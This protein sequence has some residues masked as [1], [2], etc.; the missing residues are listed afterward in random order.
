MSRRLTRPRDGLPSLGNPET[1][2]SLLKGGGATADRGVLNEKKSPSE[3]SLHPGTGPTHPCL[4][5][6][7]SN[8]DCHLRDG[9]G[10]HRAVRRAPC[11]RPPA[12]SEDNGGT[13]QEITVTATRRALSA[14]DIP[15]SITAVSGEALEQAGI[16][17][18][19][20]LAHSMAGVNYT[21]RGPFGGV[22]G[23]TLIM[24]GLNSE[25][26]AFQEG[27]A[28]SVIPPV[29]TYVDD[30]PLFFNM[31]LQDLQRVEVLRG[32]QGTLYGS[33]S[34]GGTIRFVLNEPDPT[35]FDAKAEAG[36]SKT[37]HTHTTN[38]DI[39]GMI[40]LPLSDTLAV[41]INAGA[42][43]DAGFVNQTNLYVVDP[44]GVPVFSQQPTPDNALGLNPQIGPKTYSEQGV[45][46]YQYRNARLSVLWK[47]N[48]DFKAQL[49]YL[50]QRST[51]NG[52]P[53]IAANP[54]AYTQPI[55]A[56]NQFLP[57]G[58]QTPVSDP[59]NLLSLAPATVP[60]GTDRLT[61]ANNSLEGTADDVNLVSLSL[62][63]DMGFAT[64]TSSS[65]WAHHN[66]TSQFRPDRRIHQF[67]LLPEFIRSKSSQHH[68]RDGSAR[69]QDL[70][71]GI[72]PDLEDRRRLRLDRGTVLQE[73]E[74]QHRG[75]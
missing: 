25:S 56:A 6:A 53:I 31:R 65:S 70:C 33:G 55:A 32:P 45:N 67:Q 59:P 20:G 58:Q 29:A 63:Y 35:G 68:Q 37:N 72:S 36:V 40:N 48:E 46:S 73:P 75:T 24:R 3:T 34:L 51:A 49:T 69:R 2:E 47:P 27:L 57:Y 39:S 66:N 16:Q 22:N 14:Q 43:D 21:D 28:T 64:L 26:T 15:I 44:S 7:A 10:A 52:F 71:P 42:S 62:D 60:P 61:N 12:A 13:L 54:L 23:S 8:R 41:R 1:R 17:D 30:T 19:A 11:A 38:E 18:I 50:Y 9:G 5:P 4:R 74:N